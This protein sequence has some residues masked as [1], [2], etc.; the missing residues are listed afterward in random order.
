MLSRSWGY[1]P[2][3]EGE[4]RVVGSLC[5]IRKMFP[6][7]NMCVDHIRPCRTHWYASSSIRGPLSV[8][9]SS[10][11]LTGRHTRQLR[12]WSILMAIGS[13]GSP[14]FLWGR[15]FLW[16]R[17]PF[18]WRPLF[19]YGSQFYYQKYPYKLPLTPWSH[20]LWLTGLRVIRV[21][22]SIN[23]FIEECDINGVVSSE[24]EC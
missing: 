2:L 14:R 10:I 15:L 23:C 1:F 11:G 4:S 24:N 22:M 16:S 7:M 12:L 20:R 18:P 9:G 21:F 13:L 8:K 5:V 3:W 19:V 6:Y 17:R